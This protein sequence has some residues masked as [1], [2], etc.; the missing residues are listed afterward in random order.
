ML[1]TGTTAPVKYDV[2]ELILL[3][4]D[5]I[6]NQ[7]IIFKNVYTQILNLSQIPW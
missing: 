3:K 7:V 6:F 2:V 1:C 4:R 5:S